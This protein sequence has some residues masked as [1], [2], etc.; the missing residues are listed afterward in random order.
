M[1]DAVTVH[2]EGLKEVTDRLKA[3]PAKLQSG[4]FTKM[5]RAGGS[6][7]IKSMRRRIPAHMNTY[8][9]SLFIKKRRSRGKFDVRFTVS[10]SHGKG[11][12]YDAWYA[13][14]LEFGAKRH[15][16]ESREWYVAGTD[17][18]KRKR[19][20]MVLPEPINGKQFFHKVEH[21]G[22]PA[23]HFMLNTFLG[24]YDDVLAAIV[25]KGRKELVKQK[26]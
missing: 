18:G 20:Q 9:K 14:I 22:V 1:V 5:T 7:F 13:H 12:H 11:V 6:Q 26:L 16:I 4:T 10:P 19:K 21:P 24:D 2:I 25:G 23:Y 3:A 8:R 15:P 17:Y